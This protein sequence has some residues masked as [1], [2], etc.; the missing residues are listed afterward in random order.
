MIGW[1]NKEPRVSKPLVDVWTTPSQRTLV[2]NFRLQGISNSPF[3]LATCSCLPSFNIFYLSFCHPWWAISFFFL[4]TTS[5]TFHKSNASYTWGH[6]IDPH[7]NQTV[8]VVRSFFIVALSGADGEALMGELNI[9]RMW[10][11]KSP[12]HE[13]IVVETRDK[14]N[15]SRLFI[16]HRVYRSCDTPNAGTYAGKIIDFLSNLM[17]SCPV[18]PLSF[19]EEGTLASTSASASTPCPPVSFPNPNHTFGDLLSLSTVQAMSATKDKCG[20]DKPAVDRLL[21]QGSIYD[22]RYSCRQNAQQLKP[23]DATLF[24]LILLAQ[25]VHDFAPN[26]LRYSKNCFW[27]CGLIFDACLELFPD[28]N[29]ISTGD[30]ERRTKFEPYD[31]AISGHWM[32]WKVSRTDKEDL[33]KIIREYKSARAAAYREVKIV[34][35]QITIPY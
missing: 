7:L 25:T 16:L 28:D 24:D 19:M 27:Y 12:E 29:S 33:S 17:P 26:Y 34:F 6:I 35:N 30:E 9:V 13:Y 20:N 10:L 18:S 14:N 8:D 32:G 11:N 5:L 3:Y 1:W 23:R 21:G 4:S 31:T 15:V 2:G 22:S